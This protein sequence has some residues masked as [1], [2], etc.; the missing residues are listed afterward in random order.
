MKI[1]ILES[2]YKICIVRF[3]Q[4]IGDYKYCSNMSPRS[5]IDG[6]ITITNVLCMYEPVCGRLIQSAAF[7]KRQTSMTKVSPFLN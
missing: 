3:F 1:N 6:V 4:R 5:H 2:K 7:G